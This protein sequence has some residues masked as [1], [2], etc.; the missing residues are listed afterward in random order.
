MLDIIFFANHDLCAPSKNEG[1]L[2]ANELESSGISDLSR[3]LPTQKCRLGEFAN[4]LRSFSKTAY[5]CL[6]NKQKIAYRTKFCDYYRKAY[7]TFLACAQTPSCHLPQP[8]AP[9]GPCPSP[10]DP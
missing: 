2:L 1:I 7:R 5:K 6:F 3:L 10:R 9:Y 4:S 8:Q